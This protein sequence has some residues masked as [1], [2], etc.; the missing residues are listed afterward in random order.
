MPL[1]DKTARAAYAKAYASSNKK[2]LKAYN[3][4]YYTENSAG[5]CKR[6]R[7]HYAANREQKLAYAKEYRAVNKEKLAAQDREEWLQIKADPEKLTTHNARMQK[8]H[9]KRS[10]NEP[11][12]KLDSRVRTYLKA[13]VQN[14]NGRTWKILGYTVEELYAHLET[15][16]LEG[17]T[18]DNYGAGG[19]VIDHIKP[20]CSFA[21]AASDDPAF[22]ECWALANLRPLWEADN[23][24]KAKE[25]KKLS[26]H[27]KTCDVQFSNN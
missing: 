25:D 5:I 16:F 8:Y 9:K 26:V 1:K 21:Y 27:R 2:K 3:Q 15:Q 19:W 20:V 4:A 13:C 6:S 24:K 12:F 7:N 23:L 22:K 14:K 10:A 18:W 11:K 17:I